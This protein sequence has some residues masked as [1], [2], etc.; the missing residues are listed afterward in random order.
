VQLRYDG[1]LDAYQR[2]LFYRRKDDGAPLAFSTQ[3]QR[4]G[5]ARSFFEWLAR[6]NRILQDPAAALELPPGGKATPPRGAE[7]L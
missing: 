6:E 2:S 5:A 1:V 3:A 7:R 4:L